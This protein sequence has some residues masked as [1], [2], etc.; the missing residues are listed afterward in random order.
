MKPRLGQF[1]YTINQKGRRFLAADAREHAILLAYA[2]QEDIA[3]V[4]AVH[5]ILGLGF[6]QITD[7]P[8]RKPWWKS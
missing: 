4:A 8:P 6:A 1:K 5:Y 3:L 7:L 2:K